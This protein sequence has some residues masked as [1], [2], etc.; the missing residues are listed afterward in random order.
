[1]DQKL[2]INPLHQGER[3]YMTLK[4]H[5]TKSYLYALPIFNLWLDMG[6]KPQLT[7]DPQ[8]GMYFVRYY[9]I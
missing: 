2:S 3:N 8:D 6:R 5:R 4:F 9:A 7:Y 1:M